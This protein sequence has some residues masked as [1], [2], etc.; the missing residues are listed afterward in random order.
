MGNQKF[1]LDPN[2]TA[3]EN[4]FRAAD[5]AVRYILSRKR[6]KLKSDEEWEEL[7]NRCV[8][9]GVSIF[10]SRYIGNHKYDR[11]FSFYQNVYSAVWSCVTLV[12]TS[13]FDEIKDRL[14]STDHMENL[15][16]DPDRHTLYQPET[17]KRAPS[18]LTT[19][20][21]ETL[22]FDHVTAWNAEEALNY[23]WSCEDEAAEYDHK[24]IDT[25][26]N[27]EHR[28]SVLGRIDGLLRKGRTDAEYND[29]KYYHDY[30]KNRKDRVRSQSSRR[31]S[32]RDSIRG[33]KPR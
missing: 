32:C 12:V 19:A 33:A 10:M 18:I 20:E 1:L 7:H 4:L 23:I 15:P 5:Y 21:R 30:Y 9:K 16:Y 25:A 11:A 13:F 14:N 3:M 28:K 6:I 17:R 29:L 2:E 26:A 31:C 22:G 24:T 27:L 8:Y